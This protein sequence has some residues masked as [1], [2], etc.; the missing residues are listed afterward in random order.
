MISYIEG[1]VF[2]VDAKS[3]TLIVGG[4]GYQV[5]AT[6]ETLTELQNKKEAG[7]FTYLAIRENAEDL[8]GFLSKEDRDFF[9]LLI[10]IPGIGPKSALA[11]LNVISV[12][13]LLSAISKNDASYLTKV[14]GI[15]KKTADK[16]ILELQGKI[17]DSGDSTTFKDEGDVLEVLK[18][19]GYGEKEI[20]TTLKN[21]SDSLTDTGER[22]KA[23][24]K[25][26][27]KK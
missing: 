5:F 10:T 23:A 4:I 27:G 21:I 8:Y 6:D 19:L 16:I 18:T 20:R 12:K 22:V 14:S 2:E 9:K 15:G 26:L 3:T 1:V 17:T 11:I 24:L 13:T 7:L 25:L